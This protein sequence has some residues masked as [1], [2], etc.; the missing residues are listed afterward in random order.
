MK[1]LY[2]LC[3]VGSGSWGLNHVKTLNRLNA[4][5]GVVEKNK[6]ITD[7]IAL[8]YFGDEE[9]DACEDELP[10]EFIECEYE[11]DY[12]DIDAVRVIVYCGDPPEEEEEE[13][14]AEEDPEDENEEEDSTAGEEEEDS[15]GEG[16]GDE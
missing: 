5:G 9:I 8:D 2:K 13:D 12:L 16:E 6:T 14:L 15:Q 4:L 11:Y 1:K 10:E 3:V 7:Q